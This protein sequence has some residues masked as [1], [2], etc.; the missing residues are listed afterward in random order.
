LLNVQ[1]LTL[2]VMMKPLTRAVLIRSREAAE[3]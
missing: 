2:S 3:R 1:R